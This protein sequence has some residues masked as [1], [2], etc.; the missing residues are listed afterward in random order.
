MDCLYYNRCFDHNSTA[1]SISINMEYPIWNIP[2][3]YGAPDIE[4]F[5]IL[6]YFGMAIVMIGLM[7][8]GTR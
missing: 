6:L 3:M 2:M 7:W 8:W 1:Y 4:L 5:F